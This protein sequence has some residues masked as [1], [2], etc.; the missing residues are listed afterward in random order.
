LIL[1]QWKIGESRN[2]NPYGSCEGE[3]R[4]EGR[5]R[6]EKK[7]F[8]LPAPY[9]A[10]FDSPSSLREVSTWRFREQIARSKKT[11]ALQAKFGRSEQYTIDSW[12]R[13]GSI[14]G[15]FA[16]KKADGEVKSG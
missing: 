13:D 2:S 11:P 6:G 12:K 1:R 3:R 8:S 9:P 4:K 16:W 15:I 5:G 14:D 10:P 7:S